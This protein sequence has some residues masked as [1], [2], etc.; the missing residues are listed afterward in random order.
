M[1]DELKRK[2]LQTYERTNG[3]INGY[4]VAAKNQA[5]EEVILVAPSM[6]AIVRSAKFA[7]LCELN[8]DRVQS[9]VVLPRCSVLDEVKGD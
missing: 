4:A 5:G 3:G 8:M 9:V 7:G 2:L 1:S 6:E